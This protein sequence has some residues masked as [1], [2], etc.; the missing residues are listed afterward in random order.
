MRNSI[1]LAFLLSALLVNAT[2]AQC[3][4]SYRNRLSAAPVQTHCPNL[5]PRCQPSCAQVPLCQF[6]NRAIYPVLQAHPVV[7]NCA[8]A[9]SI[10]NPSYRHSPVVSQAQVAPS[11]PNLTRSNCSCSG[12]STN[13]SSF[14]P[15]SSPQ[16]ASILETRRNPFSLAGH[17]HERKPYDYCLQEFLICC[18]SGGKNC[19][20]NY[21]KCGEITGE[22]LRYNVCPVEAPTVED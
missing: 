9:Q 15:Q 20:L 6:N 19:M 8:L 21:Y 4:K 1:A 12:G 22:P 16:A 3:R 13:T 11:V 18:E 5:Q 7:P 17:A 2:S 10:T 14:S